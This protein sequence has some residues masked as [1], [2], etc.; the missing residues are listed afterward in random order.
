RLPDAPRDLSIGELL[1][2]MRSDG[3]DP[4]L[5]DLSDR[6]PM[7]LQERGWAVMKVVPVGYQPLRIDKRHEFGWHE[8]RLANADARTGSTARTQEGTRFSLPHPLP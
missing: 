2:A 6:L 5:V 1:T 3:T 4:V 7:P 8:H